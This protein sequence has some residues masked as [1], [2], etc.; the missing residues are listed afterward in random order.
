M[1]KGDWKYF[2]LSNRIVLASAWV[3]CI[4]TVLIRLKIFK[5]Q[6]DRKKDQPPSDGEEDA[7]PATK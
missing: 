2:S 5:W 4:I 7:S 3:A 1:A 6:Q